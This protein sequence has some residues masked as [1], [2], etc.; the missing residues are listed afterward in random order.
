MSTKL[1]LQRSRHPSWKATLYAVIWLCFQHSQVR[2]TPP[3]GVE[4]QWVQ[5]AA[6]R[7]PRQRRS[8]TLGALLILGAT[9]D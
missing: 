3:C 1:S 6:A 8:H 9:G 2:E 7:T 4:G 5:F